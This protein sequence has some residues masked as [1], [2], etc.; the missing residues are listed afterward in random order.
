MEK[1]YRDLAT[2]LKEKTGE[3]TVKLCIDGG[4]TCPNRDGSRST[5]GCLFCGARGAGDFTLDPSLAI[6]EQVHTRLSAPLGGRRASRFIAYFQSFSSTYAP[7][8]VLRARYDAALCDA[9]VIGLAV[10]TRPDCVDEAVADLLA[11]YA[12]HMTVWVELGL[13]TASDETAARMNLACPRSEFSRAVALLTSRG[14]DTVAHMMVGLPGEGREDAL[15][16]L[17]MI[18][19]HPVCGVKIHSLYVMRDTPLAA[20]WQSGE[21]EPL[22]FAEY[23]ETVALLLAHLRPDMVVHRL[24]GDCP[25]HELLAPLWSAEKNKVLDRIH[26]ILRER[27]WRQGCLYHQER[28]CRIL[29]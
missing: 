10:A 11:E 2:Y 24:T 19:A 20:M 18:N 29:A 7:P 15:S 21:Y 6:A 3:K 25:K 22:T 12:A 28:G 26:A 13:Q 23:T 9:R 27:G 17:R 14:V 16:T 5:G 8:V 4:F 1:P